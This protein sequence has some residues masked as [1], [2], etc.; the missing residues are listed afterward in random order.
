MKLPECICALKWDCPV[1]GQHGTNA[2]LTGAP[3]LFRELYEKLPECLWCTRKATRESHNNEA[4][5]LCDAHS[6]DVETGEDVGFDLDWAD[7]VRR[8]E[9]RSC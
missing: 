8:E 3:G 9:A 5:L 6:T 4:I 7:I 2:E 1:H